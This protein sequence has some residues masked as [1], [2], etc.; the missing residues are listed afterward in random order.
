MVIYIK[1]I[2]SKSFTTWTKRTWK[3]FLLSMSNLWLCK[4]FINVICSN[5]RIIFMFLFSH[6]L[7][8]K[9]NNSCDFWFYFNIISTNTWNSFLLLTKS[10]NWWW[11][12]LKPPWYFFYLNW[13]VCKFVMISTWRRNWFIF[14]FFSL[15]S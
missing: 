4:W 8:G 7:F 10:S 2:Y 6:C 11:K 15:L 3:I 12:T 5:P 14:H 13:W 9:R 1:N